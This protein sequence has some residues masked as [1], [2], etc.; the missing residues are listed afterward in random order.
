MFID[1]NRMTN[2]KKFPA[3]IT[4]RSGKFLTFRTKQKRR[5]TIN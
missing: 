2:I 4:T 5:S 1:K 3:T